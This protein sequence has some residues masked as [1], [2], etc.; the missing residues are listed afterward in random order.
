[1]A[2]EAEADAHI[3]LHVTEVVGCM[4]LMA[5]GTPAGET[6]PPAPYFTVETIKDSIWKLLLAGRSAAEA[7]EQVRLPHKCCGRHAGPALLI[8]IPVPMTVAKI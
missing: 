6:L 3:A 1:M 4:L 7:W 2:T 5:G 8:L